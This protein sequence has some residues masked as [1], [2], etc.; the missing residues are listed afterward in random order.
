MTQPPSRCA[1]RAFGVAAC[2]LAC[3]VPAQTQTPRPGFQALRQNEDWSVLRGG[4]LQGFDRLK[5]IALRDDGAIWASIGGEGRLRV[6]GVD[7]N[8]F[9]APPTADDDDVYLLTRGRVHADLHV[10]PHARAFV[11]TISAWVTEREL[12]GGRRS[13]DVDSI[14]LLQAFLDMRAPLVDDVMFTLRGGRQ[15]LLFGKQRLVSPLPWAN[16]MRA[17]DGVSAIADSP[18]FQAWAFLTQFVPPQ[19]Y[20]FNDVNRG[21]DFGGIH[22]TRKP[23]DGGM[24]LDVYGLWLQKDVATFNGTS[25]EEER[26]TIGSR[27]WRAPKAGA[28]DYDAEAAV[29]LGEHAGRDIEAYMLALQLGRAFEGDL[30]PRAF[31]GLDYASGDKSP[32]G[33]VQ[34]FN[35]L[36]PL[37]HAHLGYIDIIGRQNI[38]DAS[39]G[40]GVAL[41]DSIKAGVDGHAFWLADRSDALYDAGGNV[42]R[43][44]GTARSNFVGYE[45]DATATWQANPNLG[46]LLGLSW[47][48]AGAMIEDSGP[49]EDTLFG[50]LQATLT[51]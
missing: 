36:F 35:Q 12:V 11:E 23:V 19:K 14:D 22:V 51:F 37:G 41:T 21:V 27:V 9:G 49:S 7:G 10:G 42:V 16:A 24:G 17:W 32:G 44:G 50:Y 38:V 47:F 3:S 6:E 2:A 46:V 5:Y 30:K 25:G 18:S 29:Q 39:A 40:F 4:E 8:R 26:Y 33:R 31:V 1:L 20:A 15:A 13:L 28:L 45:V 43:A 34:T 48:G